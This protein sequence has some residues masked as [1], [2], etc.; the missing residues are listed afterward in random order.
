MRFATQA[1][2]ALVLVLGLST[3]GSSQP[4]SAVV[5]QCRQDLSQ[6]LALPPE[7]IRVLRMR[8]VIFPD[9]SLGLPRPGESPA[10]TRVSGRV[11]VLEAG[12]DDYLYTTSETRF[13]YGGPL[14][15]WKSSAL[16]I[17]PVPGDANLNGNLVQTSLAG[18][19]PTIRL[20]R[21]CDFQPQPDGSILAWRRLSRSSQEL[22]FLP[23]RRKDKERRLLAAFDLAAGTLDSSRSRWAC[24]MRPG[25]GAPWALAQNRLDAAADQARLS[26]LPAQARPGRVFWEDANPVIEVTI[27]G[28]TRHFELAR[29]G[30]TE[31]WRERTTWP[32]P[33]A[34]DLQLNKSQRLVVRA[35][36]QG[37]ST[38]VLEVW[39][40]GDERV[41]A[42]IPAFEARQVSLSA[43]KDFMVI[44]GRRGDE[45]RAVTV[46]L[47]TG[48]ILPLRRG[49]QRETR[50]FRQ[51]V[52]D[53]S[54]LEKWLRLGT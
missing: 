34:R 15:S 23:T 44:S 18:T 2:L 39:S 6:R 48:E 25:A 5:R 4:T 11:L 31:T 36:P 42:S 13:R 54:R 40:S 53:W 24:F 9:A 47:S 29:E 7:A 30:E 51:P 46:D 10:Q 35:S 32:D 19:N 3:W 38:L 14:R 12:R 1:A 21:V 33:L 49:A 20:R 22:L 17:H 28:A 16:A 43:E 8:Q 26:N 37:R 45:S 41:L 50:L 52:G 27:S